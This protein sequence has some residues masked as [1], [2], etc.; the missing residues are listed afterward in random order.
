MRSI[1]QLQ[2]PAGEPIGKAGMPKPI[3]KLLLRMLSRKR[4]TDPRMS[5]IYVRDAAW[6]VLG[7]YG[8]M[9]HIELIRLRLCDITC[10]NTATPYINVHISRSKTDPRGQGH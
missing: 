10:H 4:K 9:R 8:M 2:D 5:T 3:L 7:S 1:T 6:V